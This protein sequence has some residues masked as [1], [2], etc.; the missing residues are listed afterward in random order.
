MKATFFE[1][2]MDVR[3]G[4]MDAFGHLNNV[5]YFRY[6]E[7]ARALWLASLGVGLTL[8][9]DGPVLVSSGATYFHPVVY[10]AR[11]RVR[12]YPELLG[13]T[14]FTVRH[15]VLLEGD[16]SNTVYTEGR[17]KIVWISRETERP[18]RVPDV[19]RQLFAD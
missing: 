1:T 11:M 4:E 7:E 12:C 13:N 15:E 16:D 10:P 6:F 9:D 14:S 18:T 5:M 8:E 3:W 17:A 2:V 19:I